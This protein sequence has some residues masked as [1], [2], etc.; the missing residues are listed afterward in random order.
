MGIRPDQ[1]T[2]ESLTA[3]GNA[4]AI[5]LE[6][7]QE[8]YGELVNFDAKV[9]EL[10]LRAGATAAEAVGVLRLLHGSPRSAE[11]Y[12]RIVADALARIP[13]SVYEV[14][15]TEDIPALLGVPELRLGKLRTGPSAAAM[16]VFIVER[17]GERRMVRLGG[18][19]ALQQ[20]RFRRRAHDAYGV[21]PRKLE[22]RAWDFAISTLLQAAKDIVPRRRPS[23]TARIGGGCQK[24][25]ATPR[26][27]S[28]WPPRRKVRAVVRADLE[29]RF[30]HRS[31]R[32]AQVELA[33]CED[34]GD[35]FTP[36]S[37]PD[38]D[39]LCRR[40]WEN[41]LYPSTRIPTRSRRRVR[42]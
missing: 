20:G 29:E 6:R 32:A 38:Q 25:R 22:A 9:A 21:W 36:G 5:S 18:S 33:E 34:C 8:L 26:P 23:M 37:G 40:C 4:A 3:A 10:A 31:L 17:D 24:R 39:V 13:V 2:P 11:N 15:E 16:F 19:T 42:L 14:M 27:E 35:R 28:E 1:R 7:L 12:T 30:P 41:R